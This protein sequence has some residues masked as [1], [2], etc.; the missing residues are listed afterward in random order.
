[1]IQGA[2]SIAGATT[3]AILMFRP[4]FDARMAVYV[5]D[6]PH[7]GQDS[8]G[9]LMDA[10]AAFAIIEVCCSLLFYWAQRKFGRRA[11]S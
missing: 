3:L 7:D 10:L 5:R 9:A 6:Y 1:L 2:I 11:P 8:L 4:I